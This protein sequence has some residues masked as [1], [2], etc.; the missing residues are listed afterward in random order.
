MSNLSWLALHF[1]DALFGDIEILERV[2]GC[3]FV[4]NIGQ[5]VAVVLRPKLLRLLKEETRLNL[6][7]LF[8][9]ALGTPPLFAGLSCCIFR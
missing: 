9:D 4:R 6:G 7:L 1:L 2:L 5:Q 8:A 3:D